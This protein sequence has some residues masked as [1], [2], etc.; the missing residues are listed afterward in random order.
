M[1]DIEK[2]NEIFEKMS[3]EEKVDKAY[4]VFR[5]FMPKQYCELMEMIEYDCHI[6]TQKLYDKAVSLLKWVDD[7]G[8]GEKWSVEKV[9]EYANMDFSQVDYYEYDLAYAMNMF[10]S[11]FCNIFTDTSHYLKMAKNYLSDNDYMGEPD[12][13]AYHNAIE[14]LAYFENKE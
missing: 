11:D 8:Q 13:R 6:G 12:K 14:R 10:W 3:T 2:A 1:Y 7:K 5:S 9:I 4:K